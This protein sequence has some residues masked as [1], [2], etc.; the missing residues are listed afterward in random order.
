MYLSLIIAKLV[1]LKFGDVLKFKSY[2]TTGDEIQ[3]I[4]KI[5]TGKANLNN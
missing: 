1:F 3:C 5:R 4:N 2:G